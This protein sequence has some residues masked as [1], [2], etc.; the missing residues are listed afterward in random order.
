[1]V[2]HPARIRCGEIV[3]HMAL[4]PRRVFEENAMN[5]N[6]YLALL[7]AIGSAICWWPS[8]FWEG[9]FPHDPILSLTALA[10]VAALTG[11]ST[12]LSGGRWVR[13]WLLSSVATF[14]GVLSG[15]C[16]WP[17]EDAEANSWLGIAAMIAAIAVLLV[18]LIAALTARFLVRLNERSREDRGCV[19]NRIQFHR[20]EIY[21]GRFAWDGHPFEVRR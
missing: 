4:I 16:I 3:E 15:G 9:Y 7:T 19:K 18:S 11:S 13:Y 10:F 20:N 17:S 1:M 8:F 5:R 14:L 21:R 6:A 2:P 12:Y